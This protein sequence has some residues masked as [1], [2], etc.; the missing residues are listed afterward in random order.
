[1]CAGD[2][3]GYYYE[4]NKVI[5]MLNEWDWIGVSGNHEEMLLRWENET[6]RKEIKKKYGS[7]IQ[8]ASKTLSK[9][10]ISQLCCLTYK[11]K[12][13]ID[14]YKIIICHGSP[15]D[16]DFYIYP[17]AEKSIINKLFT[18]DTDF[19][20]LLYGHTHYPVKWEKGKQ[21]II[22]PG[23]VGQPRDKKPG[24][25]WAIWDSEDNSIDFFRED[26]DLTPVIE[27]CK[28]YD[29]ELHYLADVLLRT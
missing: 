21:K 15:W 22:N 20:L 1:M 14:K 2:Y 25:C 5:E 12:I 18:F 27:M 26:Y 6:H 11:K 29:P 10:L 23:S 3:V 8:I 13:V 17:D 16:Y 19:D 9:E 7:G 24:V 4:P 28:Q